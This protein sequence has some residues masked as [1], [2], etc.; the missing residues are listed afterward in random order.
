MIRNAGPTQGS[1]IAHFLTFRRYKTNSEYVLLLLH[2]SEDEID[3]LTRIRF[4]PGR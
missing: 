3:G 2:G 1:F 4:I